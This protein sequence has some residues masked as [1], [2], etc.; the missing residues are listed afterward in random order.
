MTAT[1]S[2]SMTVHRRIWATT[3]SMFEALSAGRDDEFERLMTERSGLL[4]ESDQSVADTPPAHVK[5]ILTLGKKTA[6]LNDGMIEMIEQARDRT[7]E[8]LGSLRRGVV[9]SRGYRA[10]VKRPGLI[11]NIDG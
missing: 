8:E 9:A 10:R 6:E 5:E 1:S 4:A 11:T 3:K 7:S 2:E